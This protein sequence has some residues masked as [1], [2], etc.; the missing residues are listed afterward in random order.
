[1]G[2]A[3]VWWVNHYAITPESSGGTRHYDFATEL[4][5]RGHEVTVFACD[6]ALDTRKRRSLKPGQLFRIEELDGARFVWINAPEY[7]AN[8]WRRLINV[9]VFSRNLKAV[10]RLMEAKPDLIIGSSPSLNAAC[11]AAKIAKELG[12][13]FVAELRDL[14]PQAL[15]DMGEFSESHPGVRWMR[16]ME[17]F[18]YS[19]AREFIVL[20]EGSASYLSR[21]GI[22]SDRVHYIPNGVNLAS[23][24]P[25]HPR[26][27]VR[28]RLGFDKFTIVYAGAHSSANALGTVVRVASQVDATA[29]EFVLVGDGPQ[30]AALQ[31]LAK[32]TNSPVRFLDPVSKAEMPDLLNAAD[33]ALIT[34]K[35]VDAFGYSVSPNKLFDYMGAGKP[36]LCAVPGDMATLVERAGCGLPVPAE[37]PEALA[38]RATEMSRF[39]TDVLAAM[40]RQGMALVRDQFDRQKL[41]DELERLILCLKH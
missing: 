4:A 37:N 20:A 9:I 16:R 34:L 38:R 3:R 29:I 36:V 32:E 2:G 10:C 26:E 7:H 27:E 14:W 8:N 24:Q 13:P 41:T 39:P 19:S 5:R 28:Q 35:N 1:M 31:A 18:L 23:F 30:K 11:A 33:A 17:S 21:R 6:V 40:G 25:Q 22:A 12:V 15:V